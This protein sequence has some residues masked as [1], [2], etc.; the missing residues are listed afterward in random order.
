[1]QIWS[2]T[3]DTS[4]LLARFGEEK[5]VYYC[6]DE[7]ASF[8]GYDVDQVLRGEADLCRRLAGGEQMAPGPA[9]ATD[10]SAS[11]A[12]QWALVERRPGPPGPLPLRA[13]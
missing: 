13:S 5:V 3:P 2:F 4:Y 9:A 12:A 11:S 7:F 6:V 1:M 10:Q 8:S